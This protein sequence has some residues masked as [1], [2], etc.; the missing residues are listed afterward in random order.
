MTDLETMKQMLTSAEVTFTEEK[1]K[2]CLS[3]AALNKHPNSDT[4]LSWLG[5]SHRSSANLIFDTNG[6]LVFTDSF[7]E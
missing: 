7:D 2:N 3:L 5:S 1:A 6:K 4:V